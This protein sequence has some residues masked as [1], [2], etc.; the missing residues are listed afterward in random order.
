MQFVHPAFLFA[1]SALAIPIIIHLFNFRRFKRVLF[2]NVLFLKEVKEETSSRSKLKHLLVLLSRLLAFTFLVLA[3]AQPFIPLTD[4][5]VHAG[6]NA[7]SIYLDNS[8]SMES[9]AGDLTALEEARNKAKAIVQAYGE[10]S[11]RLVTNDL[12]VRHRNFVSREEV[13][14][15]IDEV[16][17]SPSVLDMS[18]VADL[19]TEALRSTDAPNRSAY[20]ISDMQKQNVQLD[21]YKADTGIRYFLMPIYVAGVANLFIDT[22][23]F[24]SPKPLK[25]QT[26]QLIVKLSNAGA[27]DIEA[28]R[29]T[30]QLNQKVKALTDANVPAGGTV[31]DTLSFMITETG[32]HKA[33]LEV[34]DYPVSFDDTYYFTFLVDDALPI[35]IVSESTASPYLRAVFGQ[36][37]LFRLEETSVGQINYAALPGN[38]M[39]ILDGLNSI[40]SGLSHALTEY[41]RRGGNVMQFIGRDATLSNLNEF[42]ATIQVD[43]ISPVITRDQKIEEINAAQLVFKD[44]FEQVPENIDLPLIRKYYP[45]RRQGGSLEEVLLGFKDGSSYLS[46]YK[47][48]PGSFYLCG[49]PL[50]NEFTDL[51]VHAVFAPMLFRMAVSSEH[52]DGLAY[53]IGRDEVLE[54]E[55]DQSDAEDIFKIAG[56]NVEFIPE[57][58]PVGLVS[59]L[60]LHGR[61]R[62]SGYYSVKRSSEESGSWVAFNYDRDES[63][64]QYLNEDQVAQTAEEVGFGVLNASYE[65]VGQVISDWNK[66]VV[67]WKLCI[68]FA[69]MS[70]AAEVLLLKFW[71]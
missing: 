7:V 5:Q 42:L 10:A 54:I 32:W 49:S 60:T 16:R 51:P 1:L 62:D 58:R 17:V 3:F 56:N 68:I 47:V 55:V 21:D 44:V 59:L 4:T 35:L 39:I 23:W 28:A 67:L 22:A 25:G 31:L 36:D 38:R 14:D 63:E 61:I 41:L 20:L 57:Y 19:Q 12:E 13:L 9:N 34:T 33:V 50:E 26:S 40:P 8:F 46:H 24:Y 69:L 48:G 71:I 15:L 43:Q 2:T 18:R 70:L 6:G 27:E 29:L 45:I 30:L 65:T 66:G 64:L 53:T 37:P 52:A 11:F